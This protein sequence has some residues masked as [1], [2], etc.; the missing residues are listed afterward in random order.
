MVKNDLSTEIHTAA[1]MR[2]YLEMEIITYIILKQERVKKYGRRQNL[3]CNLKHSLL[4]STP[5]FF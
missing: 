3:P 4:S 2:V 1:E 5:N